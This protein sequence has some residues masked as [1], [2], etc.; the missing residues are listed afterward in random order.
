MENSNL[1]VSTTSLKD[2]SSKNQMQ[3]IIGSLNS[4]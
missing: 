1:S 4:L 2:N 3:A